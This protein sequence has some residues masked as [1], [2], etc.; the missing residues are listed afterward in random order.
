M[1]KLD[2][3]LTVNGVVCTEGSGA[4]PL[5]NTPEDRRIEIAHHCSGFV[6]YVSVSGITGERSELP[7][8]TIDGVAELRTHVQTPICVGFGIS[9]PQT[10]RTVCEVADG[11]IVG[12][13]IIHRITDAKD[14]GRDELVKRLGEFVSELLAPLR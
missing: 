5:K 12:S 7:Q 4:E 6:Y 3:N 11:A 13:A 10:V 1:E 8:A 14:A 9:N 2:K